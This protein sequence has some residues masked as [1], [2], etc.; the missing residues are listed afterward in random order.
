MD[1]KLFNNLLI[2]AGLSK[3]EFA[4]MVGTGQGAVNNWGT[5]SRDVPYWV[6]SWLEL[7]IETRER[8]ELERLLRSTLERLEA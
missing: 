7:Y 3:K 8:E 1:K 2:Q 4:A 6:K 5:G